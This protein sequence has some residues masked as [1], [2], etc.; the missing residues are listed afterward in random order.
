MDESIGLK[1]VTPEVKDGICEILQYDR[2]LN[3][4]ESQTDATV[5]GGLFSILTGLNEGDPEN[6][7]DDYQNL[8]ELV[9]EELGYD[10]NAAKDILRRLYRITEDAEKE[11]LIEVL[12]DFD[13]TSRCIA[14]MSVYPSV[15]IESL[16]LIES[17]I[18]VGFYP[19]LTFDMEYIVSIYDSFSTAAV[20][21][22][23]L[24]RLKYQGV[25]DNGLPSTI[26][27]EIYTRED[28]DELHEI[29]SRLRDDS[30]SGS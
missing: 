18:R 17:W 5:D 13:D 28:M 16:S 3:G 14:K 21:R 4:D 22:E 2:W 10:F 30:E 9:F 11:D 25:T 7:I 20:Y 24:E 26:S 15:L 23:N 6:M 8:S 12:T 27:R 1:D 19:S 29:L